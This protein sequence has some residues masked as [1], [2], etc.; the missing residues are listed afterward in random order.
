MYIEVRPENLEAYGY[1]AG[2]F[3]FNNIGHYKINVTSPV[4][5]QRYSCFGTVRDVLNNQPIKGAKISIG[6]RYNNT[7]YSFFDT[8][9]ETDDQGNFSYYI[10]GPDYYEN[11]KDPNNPYIEHKEVL[12]FAEKQN[13]HPSISNVISEFDILEQS[14]NIGTIYMQNSSVPKKQEIAV[15]NFELNSLPFNS[16]A[17][18]EIFVFLITRNPPS[19]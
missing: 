4:Q 11:Y 2:Y 18:L 9:T 8:Q 12:F 3:T 15:F 19:W 6:N 10:N 7:S 1:S 13:Y 14:I 5:S 16:P 17:N